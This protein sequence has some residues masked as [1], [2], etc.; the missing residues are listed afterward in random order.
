[1][2]NR[3]KNKVKNRLSE[4][5]VKLQLSHGAGIPPAGQPRKNG[6]FELTAC[7]RCPKFASRVWTVTWDTCSGTRPPKLMSD[8]RMRGS[9]NQ[10]RSKVIS[11]ARKR[12]VTS[13]QLPEPASAGGTCLHDRRCAIGRSAFIDPD[14]NP[15]RS[16]VTYV[17]PNPLK[18]MVNS[19]AISI[20]IARGSS[21]RAIS[22]RAISP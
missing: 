2:A 20:V 21:S 15:S 17:K 10:V 1:M 11:P 13:P 12:W 6:R 16:N 7:S 19:A 4:G 22:I 3:L 8:A 14:R 5:S 18:I 9:Q